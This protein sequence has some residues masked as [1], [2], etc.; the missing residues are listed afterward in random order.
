VG[1]HW[2]HGN[3][4]K[5]TQA[6]RGWAI[7]NF[8]NPANDVRST[9]EVEVKWGVHPTG[10]KRP[11]WTTGDQRTTLLLLVNGEFRIDLTEGNIVLSEQGDYALWDRASII[12]GKH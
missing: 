2:N 6:T 5:D 7:G 8:I 1:K 4:V 3:A 10:D 9:E 11:D 12:P